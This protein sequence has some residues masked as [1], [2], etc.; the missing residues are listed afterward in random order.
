MNLCKLV[1]DIDVTTRQLQTSFTSGEI[2][3]QLIGRTDDSGY[4]SGAYKLENFI[5]LPQGSIRSRSGFQYVTRAKNSSYPV[6]LIPFRF[7]S[8]QT[9]VLVF[10]DYTMRIVTEGKEVLN[11]DGSV[12]EIT[13]PYGAYELQELDYC[14]N[15]DVITLT[16]H[17]KKAYELIRYS[18]TDWRFNAVT[19][20]PKI[21]PPTNVSVIALY[22]DR[23]SDEEAKDRTKVECSYKVTALDDNGYESEG[24]YTAS[25][26]GNYY[27]NG[28]SMQISWNAVSGAT[29]YRVYRY[30]GGVFGY[31]GETEDLYIRDTG[32]N[33]DT[34]TT[35]PKYK[36]V[37]EGE[38]GGIKDI[39]VT[40]SGSGYV[41]QETSTM[42]LPSYIQIDAIPPLCCTCFKNWYGEN[43]DDMSY[44]M[45]YITSISL[46]I[47]NT[48]N[49]EIISST[50]LPFKRI[51]IT[52][53][54]QNS[55]DIAFLDGTQKIY[56]N[57][58]VNAKKLQLK[59]VY[60]I[61]NSSL[62]GELPFYIL[63]SSYCS[64]TNQI[65]IKGTAASWSDTTFTNAEIYNQ[66][67]KNITDFVTSGYSLTKFMQIFSANN[68]TFNYPLTI[69]SKTGKDAQGFAVIENGK[70][71]KAVVTKH[72]S[73]YQDAT[74]TLNNSYGSGATFT[75]TVYSNQLPDLPS[76]VTQYDQRRVFAGSEKNPLRVWF[77]N[78]GYQDLMEYH[79]PTLND[80]RIIVDAVASD[81]DRIRHLV[82]LESLLI[83]TGSGEL[84]VYTQNSDALSPS[85]VAVRAQSYIG[86]AYAQPVILN[87][88]VLFAANRG[89]HIYAMG[90]QNS[91]GSYVSQ[92]ISLRSVHLFDNN[93][94]QALAL[95][96]APVQELWAVT[97]EG[98]LLGCTLY[99]DQ[100][101]IAWHRHVT[102]GVFEDVCVVSEGN[103]DHLY[104][105]IR[106]NGV[107]Y[108]ERMH[109]VTVDPLAKDH[110]CL[111]CYAEGEFA[112]AVQ[113]VTGLS[114]LEG[115]T[116]GV[117][118]DGKTQTNKVVKDGQITLDTAAKNI[119]VGLPY[120]CTLETV[121]LI[122]QAEG[123][124]QG[125]VK[126]ISELFLRVS[127]AGDLYANN[128]NANKLYK[129]KKDDVYMK[130]HNAKGYVVKVSTDGSWDYDAQLKVEHRDCAPIEIAS[131]VANFTIEDGK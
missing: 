77:T 106:R 48:E 76:A 22:A 41:F 125:R 127:Y 70:V 87:N 25:G 20:S 79:Q 57:T 32:D 73:N 97:D 63:G 98:Y 94:I 64:G 24:S 74:A 54:V 113:T 51:F 91:A 69:T 21:Q 102:D 46:Q 129:I 56:L 92:D 42:Y 82:A 52:G 29:R 4:K 67:I 35:P 23:L 6:R 19:V 39:A 130:P 115:K 10:G 75:V 103:E 12:Y 116:V 126:N 9:L 117:F 84:R 112:E 68:N 44:T 59:I 15:A 36:E 37:F 58:N 80:D 53:K 124:L 27:I 43:P 122:A 110:R 65:T 100:G 78:A 31:I 62:V 5:V 26:K 40:S 8:D 49:Q 14:Q 60:T 88:Q 93:N 50:A 131:L 81:A 108:I 101:V 30:L 86:S 18:S 11:A 28:C 38:G 114:Y 90:Y 107:R 99:P 118:A 119:A 120:T 85:S 13:S 89:G 47:I 16:C 123:A 105:V 66:A 3:P 33:P 72:G 1:E 111:D 121:P 71:T 128:L 55:Y 104:C 109:N 95:A 96:K 2:A 61:Y 34:S 17:Y 45:T 83:F 7:A